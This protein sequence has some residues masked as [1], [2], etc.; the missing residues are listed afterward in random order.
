MPD[1]II[2]P[3]GAGE[4]ERVEGAPVRIQL[5]RRKGFRLQEHSRALNGLPAVKVDRTTVFGNPV[6][7]QRPYGCPHDPGFERDAWADEDGSIDPFRCCVDAFRHYVETGL[8]GEPTS[9]GRFV[10][11]AEATAG[12]PRRAALVADLPR[13]RGK[14]LA[15]WCQLPAPGEPD[16]CH[17]AALLEIANR[18]TCEDAAA[19][20]ETGRRA[21]SAAQNDGGQA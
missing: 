7:C 9:T 5:S 21:L 20:T 16:L 11:A 18:P 3:E 8:R 14:N 12:Y 4:A 10:I 15:C 6:T 1:R 17:A 2:S 13:L 19:L